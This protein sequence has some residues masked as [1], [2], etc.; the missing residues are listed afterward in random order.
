[1]KKISIGALL[2]LLTV[3]APVR[4]GNLAPALEPLAQERVDELFQLIRRHEK[5]ATGL[6]HQALIGPQLTL[7]AYAATE[8]GRQGDASSVPFLIDALG[9]DSAHIGALYAQPGMATTRYRANES[10]KTLTG[11]DFDF[12]W[13]DSA[14]ERRAAIARWQDWYASRMAEE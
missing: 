5:I 3:A 7:R 10:L 8:L 11:E 12:V 9:D 13:N 2:L 14:E 6:L 1:M 4:A